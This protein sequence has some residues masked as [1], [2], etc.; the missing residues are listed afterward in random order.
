MTI[1]F[2]KNNQMIA[3]SDYVHKYSKHEL[4]EFNKCFND[5]TYFIE[6]YVKI[7]TL[8]NGLQSF[9][10]YDYQHE[11]IETYSKNRFSISMTGRQMGKTTTAAAFLLHA[12]LFNLNYTIAILANKGAQAKA[13]LD[14]VKNMYE[15][16]PKFLQQ[17]VSEWN[18]FSVELGNGSKIFAAASSS[19]SIRGRSI[20]LLYLD[21]FAFIQNE[22]E[23]YTSTYPVV[24]AGKTTKVIITSTPNGL[25]LFYKIF[26]DAVNGRNDFK[27]FIAKWDRHPDRDAEFKRQ[28]IANT[29]AQQFSQE[30]DCSFAGSGGTLIEGAILEIIPTINPIHE[31]DSYKFYEKPKEDHVYIVVVDPAEGTGNDNSVILVIDTSV[32]PFVIVAEYANNTNNPYNIAGLAVNL[33]K[34]YNE[35]YLIVEKNSIGSLVC[36][37]IWYTYEYSNMLSLNHRNEVDFSGSV[38]GVRTTRT[39]KRA[40]CRLLKIIIENKDLVIN[41]YDILHELSTFIKVGE[42]YK[43]EEGKKDDRVMALVI[44]A[45]FTQTDFFKSEF[46]L[47]ILNDNSQELYT[48]DYMFMN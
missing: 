3:S 39:T 11:M 22:I 44:F 14:M 30:H 34:E 31:Y 26:T 21:E 8:D 5:V 2:Y 19:S 20:N 46:E 38:L 16:L 24:I 40:G 1:H 48:V 42:T 29:S 41:S 13:I 4:E 6:T 25:N 33:A 10:L 7:V 18:K 12:A 28:T 35:A 9:T 45:W 32:R 27:P 37:E 23:F 43:A 17:G 47:N 15:L 36:N